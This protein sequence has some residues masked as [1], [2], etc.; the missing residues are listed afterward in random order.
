MTDHDS[1]LPALSYRRDDEIDLRD[2]ALMLLDGWKWIL[3]SVATAVVLALVFVTIAPQ[4]YRASTSYTPS[5]E[6]LRLLNEM[7]DIDYSAASTQTELELKLGSFGNLRDFIDDHPEWQSIAQSEADGQDVTLDEHL[8]L[9][10]FDKLTITRPGKDGT[11]PHQLSLVYPE[12]L[13]GAALLNDYL[14]WTERQYAQVLAQRA[15]HALETA[16]ARNSEEMQAHLE[17]Y[18]DS[19]SVE[20]TRLQE[21]HDVQL[22]ELDDQLQAEKNAERKSRQERIRTL[23]QAEAIAQRLG[24][25]QPT[26]QP[27]FGENGQTQ[28]SHGDSGNATSLPLYFMGTQAL[29][30]EKEVVEQSL[31]QEAST[32]AIREIEKELAQLRHQRQIEALQQRSDDSSFV[33]AYNQLS[34]EN[35][36]LRANRVTA[37]DIDI[38]EVVNLAYRPNRPEGP[39]KALVLAL[40]VILGSMLGVMLVMCVS[41]SRSLKRYRAQR[42]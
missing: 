17:A 37:D 34:Q 26:S 25:T 12:S 14:A 27:A 29:A 42:A 41:F 9:H 8:R 20:I 22:A 39:G 16:L 11:G 32:P 4:S 18:R 36:L 40:A 2:I 31:E 10:Y 28:V 30:A 19:V 5:S 38:I 35:T 3:G 7:P 33:D 6:G 13:Q 15:E 24:I 23:T 1:Q 21:Q